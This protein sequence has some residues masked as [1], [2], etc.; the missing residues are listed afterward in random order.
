M[1]NITD[2][3]FLKAAQCTPSNGESIFILLQV[4][5][6]TVQTRA[7]SRNPDIYPDPESF[8]PLRWVEPDYPTYQEPQTQFPTIIN[9]TQFG[10]G[11]RTCQGQAVT[12]EDLLIGIGSIAW[13]FN[14]S[15]KPEDVANPDLT[16]ST[17]ECKIGM[18]EKASISNEELNAGI[19][20]SPNRTREDGISCKTLK[21]AET[22][23]KPKEWGDSSQKPTD[24]TL[25]FS[26]L[27]IAKPNPFKFD[28]RPRD[29]ERVNKIR[30]LFK[31]GVERGDYTDNREYWGPNQGKDKP[32]GW[33]KV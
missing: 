29:A 3:T 25:D 12:D 30:N 6:L 8:N 17:K 27:L 1:M 31:E 26:I 33:S 13:L 15:Q 22:A 16:K 9:S 28:L 32:L 23:Y 11:R 10:Y 2:T 21:P 5:L 7:I 19:E 20:I 18:N 24:P 14:I 4:W